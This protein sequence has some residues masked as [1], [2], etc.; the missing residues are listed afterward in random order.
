MKMLPSMLKFVMAETI[1]ADERCFPKVLLAFYTRICLF[2]FFFGRL[3]VWVFFWG[4][5]GGC[6]LFFFITISPIL[7]KR[8]TNRKGV[9]IGQILV[10][11]FKA[12]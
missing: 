8:K 4:G 2:G 6:W 1:C 10:N 9:S 5:G 11:A 3:F 7:N 12:L